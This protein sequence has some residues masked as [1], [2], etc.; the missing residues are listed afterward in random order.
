MT[1]NSLIDT[2]ALLKEAKRNNHKEA[3]KLLKRNK[4]YRIGVGVRAD[5][6][7]L[8]FFIE[9]IIILAPYSNR[10]NLSYLEEAVKCL[11]VLHAQKY[12][13]TYQDGNCITCEAA[14]TTQNLIEKYIA[15]EILLKNTFNPS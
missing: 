12:I 3:Y 8:S 14:I 5:K 6:S 15:A 7:T 9:I 1:K 13:I 10:V 4:T 11:K 2:N